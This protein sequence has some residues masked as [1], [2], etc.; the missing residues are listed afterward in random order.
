MRP[1]RSDGLRD[2]ANTARC[3]LCELY[4]LAGGDAAR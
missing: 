4:R 1:L 2:N 3:R